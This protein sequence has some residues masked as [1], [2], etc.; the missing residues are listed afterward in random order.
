MP[1]YHAVPAPSLV[2]SR[3]RPARCQAN[4][5]GKEPGGKDDSKKREKADFSAYWSMKVR[6]LFSE[7]RKYLD[8]AE[9][10][11]EEGPPEVLVKLEEAIEQKSADLRQMKMANQESKAEQAEASAATARAAGQEQLTPAEHAV[12]DVQAAR[13]SL[14]TTSVQGLAFTLQRAQRVVQSVLMAPFSLSADALNAWQMVFRSPQYEMFLMGEGE[15]IWFWRNRTEN[16]RWFWEMYAWHVIAFPAL[17]TI[18]YQYIVPANLM[19]T[20]VVPAMF[21]LWTHG[22]LPSPSDMQFWL[23]LWFGVYLKSRHQVVDIA[24]AVFSWA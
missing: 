16:E 20:L 15:R 22:R 8:S 7:R 2:A 17:C 5:P 14:R 6:G 23:I 13:D 12:L 10:Q 1:A 19:W 21:F 18:A 24:R 3:R 11:A 9:K 4:Q